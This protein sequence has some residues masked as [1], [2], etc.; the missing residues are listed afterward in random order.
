[1][2]TPRCYQSYTQP[3]L[4]FTWFGL[5]VNYVYSMVIEVKELTEV[6]VVFGPGVVGALL[7]GGLLIKVAKDLLS[8]KSS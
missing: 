1:M 2:A 8:H 3:S 4:V 5:E 6:I 7:L